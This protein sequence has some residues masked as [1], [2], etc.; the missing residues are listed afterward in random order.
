MAERSIL[1]TCKAIRQWCAKFGGEVASWLRRCRPRPGDFA[2]IEVTYYDV[3]GVDGEIAAFET[4]TRR[5]P[6]RDEYL[7][8]PILTGCQSDFLSVQTYTLG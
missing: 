2:T 4:F 5:R 8:I 7:C 6:R 3:V 1:I